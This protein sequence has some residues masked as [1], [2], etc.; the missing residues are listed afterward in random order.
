MQKRRA[1]QFRGCSANS[2]RS[3]KDRQPLPARGRGAHHPRRASS[4]QTAKR[5]HAPL[6]KRAR[7]LD[8]RPNQ[9]SAHAFA[10]SRRVP[11]EFFGNLTALLDNRGRR[12][13]RALAAPVARLQKNSRRQSPRV[14]PR[15]PALPAR[16]FCGLYVVSPVRRAF[17]P[18]S[19]RDALASS[20]VGISVGMPGPHDFTVASG[21]SSA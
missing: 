10:I 12:E 8:D 11:P 15:H 7:D 1:A 20:Q 13:G 21:R 17:W 9:A 14:W 18:P 2:L 16:W 5:R 3:K 6:P 4:H 19:L